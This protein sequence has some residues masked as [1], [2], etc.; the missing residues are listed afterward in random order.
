MKL[1]SDFVRGNEVSLL[2]IRLKLV[3]GLPIFITL[4]LKVTVI[5][6]SGFSSDK[7][8]SYPWLY[9]SSSVLAPLTIEIP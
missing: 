7:Y 1:T 6:D 9:A 5:V 8:G 2:V 4:A 3:L